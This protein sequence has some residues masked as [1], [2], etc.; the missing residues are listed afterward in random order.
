MADSTLALT[1]S[2]IARRSLTPDD[3]G[4]CELIGARL[5]PL[6]FK[7]E[8]LNAEG[9]TN[10][11]AT[12]GSTGP[13]VVL[14]GHTDMGTHLFDTH[15]APVCDE[16]WNLFA[17]TIAR[18]PGVP[19]LIEWDEDIPEFARLEAEAAAADRVAGAARTGASKEV[20]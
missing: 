2:L 17:H 10:L 3:A 5:A 12:R 16:V 15:S 13:L 11:W 9:V 1:E 6:G 8:Y 7:L 4:C 18:M 19:V 20:A 14:A